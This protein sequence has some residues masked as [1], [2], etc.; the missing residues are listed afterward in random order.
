MD[1]MR[2]APD[3]KGRF[4]PA[5]R[6]RNADSLEQGAPSSFARKSCAPKSK[7]LAY[8]RTDTIGADQTIASFF[9]R[10]RAPPDNNRNTVFAWLNAINRSIGREANSGGACGGIQEHALK[11]GPMHDEIRRAPALLRALEWHPREGRAIPR[12]ADDDRLRANRKPRKVI[13][14]SKFSQNRAG[15]RR[16][17]QPSTHLFEEFCLFIKA[18]APSSARKTNGRA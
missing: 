15:V 16:E 13:N 11:I 10:N 2:A 14:Y 4:Q 8:K 18:D 9:Q 5:H 12:P 1:Q 6:S 7:T 17:L 3:P